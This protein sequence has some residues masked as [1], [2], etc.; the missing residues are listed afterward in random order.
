M[1]CGWDTRSGVKVQTKTATA[2]FAALVVLSANLEIRDL[3]I[4]LHIAAGKHILKMLSIPAVD[5]FSCSIAGKPWIN[6]E[7]LFQVIVFNIFDRWG[8]QGLIIMQVSIV[9]MTML[10]LYFLGH[11]KE[12]QLFTIFFLFL[13]YMVYQQRFT[14]RPDL[15]SLLFFT[16][17]IFVLSLHID[18]RWAAPVIFITQVLWSNFHGFFFFGPVFVLIGIISEFV[19]RNVPLPYEW[20]DS[21]RLTDE[22]YGRMKKILFFVI[23]ACLLNP[24]FVQGA[25]Y[26]FGIFFSLSGEDKIFFQYIQ[27]LKM[28]ITRDTL[29]NQ[30][31]YLYYKIM[32]VLSFVSFVFNRR[33]IDIS[34]LLFWLVFLFFSLKAVRNTSFFAFAA[35]LVF[36]TN[37][38]NIKY[39][40]VVPIKFTDKKFLYITSIVL[41][42][43]FVLWIF[44]YYQAISMRSYY[45]F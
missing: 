9:S 14:M 7:W 12:K 19:K 15:Y 32:I 2:I 27:E 22:E 18:K 4:W 26:P 34:A 40:D 36:I 1:N 31:E 30:G 41:K 39:D 11:S 35:Y 20:N 24:Y 5:I 42:I 10:L 8:A 45:D 6:H 33:R 28:P 29:F 16:I 3:D 44:R 43:L 23:L 38:F 21:G 25:L 37:I 17:Y 13:V